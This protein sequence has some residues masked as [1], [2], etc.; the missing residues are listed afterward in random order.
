[1]ETT[2]RWI[3]SAE[4][5]AVAVALGMPF[6]YAP[7]KAALGASKHVYCEWPL[8][9]TT[10][11]AAELAALAEANRLV[12]AIGLQA[13]GSPTLMNMNERAEGGFVGE[14]IAVC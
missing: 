1:V 14:V 2:A 8:G 6:H 10:A 11:E 5:A 9:R 12:A 3:A 4:I 13:R 7:T